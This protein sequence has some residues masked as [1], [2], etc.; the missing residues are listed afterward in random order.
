MH[1]PLPK[2]AAICHDIDLSAASG[3]SRVQV[4]VNAVCSGC[5]IEVGSSRA[6]QGSQI[7]NSCGSIEREDIAT[8]RIR[9]TS[10]VPARWLVD[11]GLRIQGQNDTSNISVDF[12]F[13]DKLTARVPKT[14]ISPLNNVT[15]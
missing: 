12:I 3:V 9:R 6:T 7:S 2:S 13:V 10:Y 5:V 4:S 14:S 1:G 8:E 15:T 11:G